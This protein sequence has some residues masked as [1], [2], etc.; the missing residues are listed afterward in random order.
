MNDP[1]FVEAS[2]KFAEQILAE[3]PS[4][5]S[6]RIAWAFRQVVS[7]SQIRQS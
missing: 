7:R 2:R 3:A 5:D 4:T 1:T 6:G